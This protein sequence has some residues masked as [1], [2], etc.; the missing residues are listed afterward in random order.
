MSFRPFFI[1]GFNQP[2]PLSSRCARGF[3]LLVS[4]NPDDS[5]QVRVQG[6]WC[7]P[8]DQ[9]TKKL[10]RSYATNAQPEVLNKRNLPRLVVDSYAACGLETTEQDQLY[11]LKYVV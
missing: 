9:F 8:K 3:T 6:T 7:S 10:G 5:R 4:P 1:H 11:L 2:G